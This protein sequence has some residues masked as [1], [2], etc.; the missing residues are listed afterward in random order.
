MSQAPRCLRWTK[1]SNR[2]RILQ[3]CSAAPASFVADF[4]QH[5]VQVVRTVTQIRDRHAFVVAVHAVAVQ[6]S[7]PE[8]IDAVACNAACTEIVAVR[9]PRE[10]WSGDNTL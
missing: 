9:E 1:A 8:W 5:V 2:N 4:L 3:C 7:D 10:H 6:L